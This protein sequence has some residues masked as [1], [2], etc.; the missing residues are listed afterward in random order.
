[1]TTKRYHG[2]DLHASKLVMHTIE[3]AGEDV[4]RQTRTLGTATL[5]TEFFP[6]LSDADVLC[7]EAS[8]CTAWF[9]QEVRETGAEV[10]VINP[11][12]FKA[13]YCTGKKTDK[14]DAKKLAEYVYNRAQLSSG[15]MEEVYVP[16]RADQKLRKGLALYR[17]TSKLIVSCQNQLLGMLR[18]KCIV[19]KYAAF[20][21]HKAEYLAHRRLDAFD[22]ARIAELEHE[23]EELRK[24]KAEL[25]EVVCA[26]AV[27]THRTDIACLITIPGISV[28]GAACI[29]ADI[30]DIH[31]FKTAKKLCSYLSSVPKVDASNTSVRIKGINKHGRKAAYGSVLQALNHLIDSSPHLKRFYEKKLMGK[32][33]CKVRAGAVRRVLTTIFYML[34]NGEVY[35]YCNDSIYKKKA[36]QLEKYSQAA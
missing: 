8:T 13:L 12:D 19:V 23:I 27:A 30:V 4:R 10:V 3:G 32:A 7:V 31:R 36:K 1:M 9:T 25:R 16:G 17:H 11:F 28:F 21:A 14:V 2:I 29:M 5:E 26:Q 35:R 33:A 20:T 24:R 15:C 6:T 22:R 34:K 18:A